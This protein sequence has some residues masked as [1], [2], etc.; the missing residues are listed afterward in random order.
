MP[1]REQLKERAKM[2]FRANY[3]NCVATFL[4]A[5]LLIGVSFYTGIG[6]ILVAIPL[7]LGLLCYFL[8]VFQGAVPDLPVIFTTGFA[9]NYGRKIGGM[10]WM[11]LWTFLWSLLFIIPGIIKFY[12][13]AMTPYILAAYPDVS[14]TD[15]L[16][17]SM[18]IM[19]G[20]KAELFVLH[21]SFIGWAFLSSFTC[22]ILLILYVGPYMQTAIV[23][24]YCELLDFAV[25]CGVVS[26][27]EL[28]GAP[29]QGPY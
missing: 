27:E 1:T 10:L 5:M 7:E 8:M 28:N 26:V 19:N 20:H 13:Y 18:R 4:I 17:L 12:S 22:G 29:L 16:K 2:T 25:K 14:A 21:L 6:A 23:G 9:I 15:A 3:G 11:G 24:Y